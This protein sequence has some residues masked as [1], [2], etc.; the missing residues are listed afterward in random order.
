MRAASGRMTDFII[1]QLNEAF[2]FSHF[3]ANAWP[4]ALLHVKDRFRAEVET[5]AAA[6][7]SLLGTPRA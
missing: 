2:G 1:R 4:S 6:E 3:G 5:F 7:I